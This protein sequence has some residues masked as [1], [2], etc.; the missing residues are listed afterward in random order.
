MLMYTLSTIVIN[1][2]DFFRKYYGG[3]LMRYEKEREQT[4]TGTFP[5]DSRPRMIVEQLLPYLDGAY[6]A[7][8]ASGRGKHQ[9]LPSRSDHTEA[10]YLHV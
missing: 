8:G 10:D 1:H 2:C 3:C 5:A 6:R 7:A 9:D 4:Y